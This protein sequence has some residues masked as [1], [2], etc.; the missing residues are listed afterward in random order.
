MNRDASGI[1]TLASVRLV[2]SF[3]SINNSRGGCALPYGGT[4]IAHP[5]GDNPTNADAALVVVDQGKF[6]L[7]VNAPTKNTYENPDRA[8]RKHPS[9]REID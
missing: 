6:T 3:D 8:H 1:K 2:T 7:R 4:D 5:K 9:T